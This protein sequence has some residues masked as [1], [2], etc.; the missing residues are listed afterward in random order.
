MIEFA[1]RHR[2]V[3][4]W[5]ELDDYNRLHKEALAAGLK[6]SA[7]IREKLG[8][9]PGNDKPVFREKGKFSKK[10]QPSKSKLRAIASDPW[11]SR[12]P[13]DWL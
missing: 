11:R 10:P 7:Y 13:E 9:D 1:R 3:N 6:D 5:F 8:F 2:Q 12:T 4:V